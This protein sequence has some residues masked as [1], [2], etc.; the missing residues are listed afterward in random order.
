MAGHSQFKNIMH[1]KGAQDSKRA[2]LF[3]RLTREIIVAAREG[4]PDPAMN[5]RLR[6]AMANARAANMPKDNIERAIKRAVGGEDGAQY[7]EV[8]YEGFAPG[9]V[10][11]IVEALTD[12]RNRTASEVRTAFAK[13][14]GTLAETG[15]VSHQFSRV[16]SIVFPTEIGTADAIFE[17]A[18]DAGAND[19][20]TTATGHEVLCDVETFNTVRDALES[21]LGSPASARLVWRPMM[22]VPVGG[23]AAVSVLELL[24]S[25]EEA[26]DVQQVYANCDIADDVVRRFG[27]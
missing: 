25:L 26:D 8:R 21:R 10:A 2:R 15:S 19:V 1:R 3:A 9:G 12:N 16:G 5:P 14:G 23:E 13:H 22:D 6:G 27:A 17:A 18:V 20:E 24:E 7:Q 11:V 4:L